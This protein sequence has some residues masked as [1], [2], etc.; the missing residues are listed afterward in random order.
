[1]K[2][3]VVLQIMIFISEPILQS[4]NF[5]TLIHHRKLKLGNSYYIVTVFGEVVSDAVAL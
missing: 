5:A 1:M 4:E 2:K 3:L